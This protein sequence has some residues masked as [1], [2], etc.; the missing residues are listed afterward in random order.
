[1][2][3]HMN[4][5]NININIMQHVVGWEITSPCSIWL[6][7]ETE[8]KALFYKARP[9]A[10]GRTNKAGKLVAGQEWVQRVALKISQDILLSDIFWGALCL[11][12]QI[13]LLHYFALKESSETKWWRFLSP[14]R[15][16]WSGKGISRTLRSLLSMQIIYSGLIWVHLS[17]PES[18]S[19]SKVALR[20]WRTKRTPKNKGEA[21]EGDIEKSYKD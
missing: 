18:F 10:R 11:P 21:R 14:G 19:Q 15:K 6:K 8:G 12:L 1:M 9:E 16:F 17:K 20:H 2:Q 5:N 7:K 13:A 3:V 4:N